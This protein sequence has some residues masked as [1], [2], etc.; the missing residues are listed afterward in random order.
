V[1]QAAREAHP[2]TMG[3]IVDEV[4]EV[5]DVA[6]DQIED[7]PHF[8]ASVNTDFIL[9]MGKV[10]EKIVML[11]DIDKV[12]SDGEIESVESIS[13]DGQPDSPVR[14]LNEKQGEQ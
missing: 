2:V 8:G 4:S 6:D 10:G 12:L 14:D 13:Q 1:V 9:G 7:S 5:L 11:L 3:I